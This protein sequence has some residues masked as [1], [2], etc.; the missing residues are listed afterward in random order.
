MNAENELNSR[1]SLGAVHGR[2]GVQQSSTAGD[3]KTATFELNMTE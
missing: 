3:E 2:G 1:T